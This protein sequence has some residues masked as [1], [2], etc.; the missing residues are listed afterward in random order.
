[1]R[2]KNLEQQIHIKFGM[3]T[4]KSASETLNLLTLV[5]DKYGMKKLSVFEWCRRFKVGQ[6]DVQEDPRPCLCVS[7][8]TRGQFTV[9]SLQRGKQ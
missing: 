9:H 3:K 6:K 4:G 1:M 7:S 2:D 8:I 5:Y